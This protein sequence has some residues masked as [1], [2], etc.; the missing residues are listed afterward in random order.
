MHADKKK[1]KKKKKEIKAFRE[2]AENWTV[3]IIN[4]SLILVVKHTAPEEAW[5]G[6]KPSVSHFRIFGCVVCVHVQQKNKVTTLNFHILRVA[7]NVSSH[8]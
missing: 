6:Y 7:T 8:L 2:K 1:K 3:H 5:S 4:R